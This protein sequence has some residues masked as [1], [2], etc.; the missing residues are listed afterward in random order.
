MYDEKHCTGFGFNS[1][2][3][4]GSFRFGGFDSNS[5]DLGLTIR[6]VKTVE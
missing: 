2:R 4:F 6:F 5:I 3:G 1:R